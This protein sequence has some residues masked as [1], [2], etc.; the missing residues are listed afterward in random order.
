[1]HNDERNCYNCNQPGHIKAKCPSK[2][3]H[4]TKQKGKTPRAPNPAVAHRAA[5]QRSGT[6]AAKKDRFLLDA[7][8]KEV[9]KIR[10]ELD[11]TLERLESEE[12]TAIRLYVS[13]H[14]RKSCEAAKIAPA[15]APEEAV[16]GEVQAPPVAA[17]EEKPAPVPPAEK[18]KPYDGSWWA[19]P[20]NGDVADLASGWMF[21]WRENLVA[22]LT[23]RDTFNFVSCLVSFIIA[24]LI[25]P[26]MIGIIRSMLTTIV[27][28]TLVGACYLWIKRHGFTFLRAAGRWSA[29][30]NTWML[31]VLWSH[32]NSQINRTPFET[33]TS[34]GGTD[35]VADSF[36]CAVA[37]FYLIVEFGFFLLLGGVSHSVLYISM[38]MFVIFVEGVFTGSERIIFF[39]NKFGMFFLR[40]AW[41]SA[42]SWVSMILN[43]YVQQ[44]MIWYLAAFITLG[45]IGW[46]YLGLWKVIA[47]GYQACL[48]RRAKFVQ[49]LPER[50][51]DDSRAFTFRNQ[52]LQDQE[53]PF[54]M[55]VSY[56]ILGITLQSFKTVVSAS[57]LAEL[58]SHKYNR[59]GSDLTDTK[60]RI[61]RACAT[62]GS[63]NIYR[64]SLFQNLDVAGETARLAFA[65]TRH[66]HE[67]ALSWGAGF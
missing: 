44:M 9:E 32:V 7:H 63:M 17:V 67:T 47:L 25:A 61:Y 54:E 11:A 49:F 40:L 37:V 59:P 8:N 38:E 15:G 31:Q 29:E 6:R 42:A 10:G 51:R 60:E 66:R 36:G 27:L 18:P 62:T 13:D 12:A 55:E 52:D 26:N 45:L 28:M 41:P 5:A 21:T 4:S 48:V 3:K 43:P 20:K 19:D 2:Q 64:F 16:A 57:L 39:F 33:I 1:M 23:M 56:E 22:Y 58:A 50:S 46:W 35:L 24:L 53:A 65:W 30:I 14:Q 34:A